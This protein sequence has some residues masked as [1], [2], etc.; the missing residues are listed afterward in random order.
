MSAPV[1]T[2]AA[3]DVELPSVPA[4]SAAVS[5][6]S[7]STALTATQVELCMSAISTLVKGKSTPEILAS[8]PAVVEKTYLLVQSFLGSD[9]TSISPVIV[10][11]VDTGL[12]M[13]GLPIAD[14]AM[15]AQVL[16]CTVPALITLIAKYAPEAEAEV[17]S[18]CT[19]LL[20]KLKSCFHCT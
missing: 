15:L 14:V 3:S 5:S 19:S 9:A 20:T 2:A 7:P 6:S 4:A 1:I 11:L 18:C 10:S 13:C 12:G 8:L 17:D 16:D